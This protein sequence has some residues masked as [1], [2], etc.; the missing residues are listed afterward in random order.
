[1]ECSVANASFA[2]GLAIGISRSTGDIF[3][4]VNAAKS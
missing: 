4:A 2:D 3:S 1:M